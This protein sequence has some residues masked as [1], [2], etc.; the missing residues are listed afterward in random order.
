MLNTRLQ[1]DTSCCMYKPVS[2][3]VLYGGHVGTGFCA[4][5][6]HKP[7]PTAS[8]HSTHTHTGMYIQQLMSFRNILYSH[9]IQYNDNVFLYTVLLGIFNT[10][11]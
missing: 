11:F 1:K 7:V 2:Q 5:S 4:Y 10:T 6:Q 8:P 3:N 9:N